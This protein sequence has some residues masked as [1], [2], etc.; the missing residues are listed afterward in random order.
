LRDSPLEVS[1]RRPEP[2]DLP[3]L[4][5]QKNDAEV[6]RMLGGF[7]HGFSRKDLEDWLESHRTRKDEVLWTIV[8]TANGRCLGHVGLYRFDPI[9][10]SAEFGIM[11]GAKDAWGKG[12]GRAAT[13]YAVKYGFQRMNLNRISLTVLADNERAIQLYLKIGFVHEGVLRQAQF[14]DGVYVDLIAM[15]MLRGEFKN[16]A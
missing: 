13:S 9:V 4:Y 7:S 11:I 8:A 12:I 2:S 15:S 1:F 10:R 3:A 6:K 14:R 16:E 5:D